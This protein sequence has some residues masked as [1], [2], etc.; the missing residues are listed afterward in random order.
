MVR[1]QRAAS[2][3]WDK[4]DS[5]HT[6]VALPAPRQPECRYPFSLFLKISSSHLIREADFIGKNLDCQKLPISSRVCC[7][8]D[9]R[10][11]EVIS[12]KKKFAKVVTGFASI[13]LFVALLLLIGLMPGETHFKAL[14]RFASV[15]GS[16]LDMS[17]FG[18]GITSVIT[19]AASA[20]VIT[21]ADRIK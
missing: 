18:L 13:I 21:L 3:S 14:G 6:W 20:C 16:L 5:R 7:V 10:R 17:K 4:T 19:I 12:T 9:I 8:L 15:V 11:R 1:S 2:A